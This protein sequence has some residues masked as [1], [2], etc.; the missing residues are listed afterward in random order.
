MRH[1]LP[2]IH[3][4]RGESATAT[5]GVFHL[6]VDFDKVFT[7]GGAYS[8]PSSYTNTL[9]YPWEEE[10]SNKTSDSLEVNRFDTLDKLNILQKFA[11]NF[12]KDLE[13][14]DPKISKLVDDN[15]WDLI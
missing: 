5:T 1:I 2:E 4:T 8:L 15:F 11:S 10:R 13:T 14:L 12:V 7:A 6:T 9:N 3:R